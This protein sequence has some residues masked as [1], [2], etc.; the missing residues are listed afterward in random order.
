MS[1]RR[2]FLHLLW[3]DG[4]CRWKAAMAV[5]AL[6]P[7]H[8]VSRGLRHKSRHYCNHGDKCSLMKEP[9]VPPLINQQVPTRT[10]MVCILL[11]QGPGC[12]LPLWIDFHRQNFLETETCYLNF[13]YFLHVI[14]VLNNFLTFL[15]L[16]MSK[17]CFLTPPVSHT[18]HS[19]LLCWLSD[20]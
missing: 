3:T 18:G 20:R 10:G 14:S 17:H 9:P 11:I 5:A 1:L 19:R 8:V 6:F 2:K 4:V 16:P 7:A 13:S 15:L 12:R